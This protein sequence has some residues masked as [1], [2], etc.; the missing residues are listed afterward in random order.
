ML[1]LNQQAHNRQG[2]GG[3]R[4]RQAVRKALVIGTRVARQAPQVASIPSLGARSCRLTCSIHRPEL[5]LEATTCSV[6]K[7]RLNRTRRRHRRVHGVW[8]DN[9]LSVSV[10]RS[11][12][13]KDH[14][15]ARLSPPWVSGPTNTGP[16]LPPSPGRSA[17]KRRRSPP[18][19]G[20][21]PS[22]ERNRPSRSCSL[23]ARKLVEVNNSP[24]PPPYRRSEIENRRCARR[25][26]K[27][28]ATFDRPGL[29]DN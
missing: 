18:G 27:G 10:P 15:A 11:A 26:P 12:R 22:R 16:D 25:S 8:K 13:R 28:E 5:P 17:R 29:A 7:H 9:H 21:R 24:D 3:A 23:G 4:K 14:S 2:A 6:E 20:G 1:P 19:I